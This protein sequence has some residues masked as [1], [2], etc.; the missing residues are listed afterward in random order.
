VVAVNSNADSV[1][2]THAVLS[3]FVSGGAYRIKQESIFKLAPTKWGT[4]DVVYSWGTA[5]HRRARLRF[6]LCRADGDTRG[7]PCV[8]TLSAHLD[9]AVL[10]LGKQLGKQLYWYAQASPA[11]QARMR[12]VYVTL[13]RLGLRLTGRRFAD[14]VTPYRGNRAMNYYHDVHD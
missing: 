10:A 2:T 6:G 4:F 12:W 9:G 3:H 14:Y 13:L 8:G 7:S 1:A 11:A 5:P